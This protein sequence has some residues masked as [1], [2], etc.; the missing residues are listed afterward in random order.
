MYI[1][2]PCNF[3][4][5]LA[6]KSDKLH[7]LFSETVRHFP[8]NSREM[9]SRN[10]ENCMLFGRLPSPRS[11]SIPTTFNPRWKSASAA[12]LRCRGVALNTCSTVIANTVRSSTRPAEFV[13]SLTPDKGPGSRAAPGYKY[14]RARYSSTRVRGSSSRFSRFRVK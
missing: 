4:Q 13:R 11:V 10:L 7:N 14:R 3:S 1:S 9:L 8:W 6:Q 2:A 5:R 12:D